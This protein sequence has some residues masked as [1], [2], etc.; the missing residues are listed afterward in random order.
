M[1]GP[2]KKNVRASKSSGVI[3]LFVLGMESGGFMSK[4]HLP[5][6]ASRIKQQNKSLL[7]REAQPP[8]NVVDYAGESGERMPKNDKPILIICAKWQTAHNFFNAYESNMQMHEKLRP[9]ESNFMGLSPRAQMY[10]S[11]LAWSNE[12][13]RFFSR[14]Q[15]FKG[16]KLYG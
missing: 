11:K 7:K 6:T 15:V 1:G 3:S 5:L 12:T 14:S 16:D 4:E 13:S 10:M 9:F 2:F 8:S